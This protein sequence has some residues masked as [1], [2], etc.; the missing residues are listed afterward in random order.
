MAILLTNG[1]YYIAHSERGAV[2]KVSDISQAQNFYTVDKAIRQLTKTPGKCKSFYWIDTDAPEPVEPM[3]QAPQ[4]KFVKIKRKHFSDAERKEL[5]NR[6][7]GYCQL[8]G[9]KITISN[10]TVDHIVPLGRGGNNDIS[11]VQAVCK[12]CNQFKANIFPEQFIDRITEIFMYQMDKKYSN[13]STWKMARNMLME[14]L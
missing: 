8:C 2:I 5:Y 4:T 11:N 1:T 9:R 3:E 10:F 14:I 12:V 6:A 7:D 13:N